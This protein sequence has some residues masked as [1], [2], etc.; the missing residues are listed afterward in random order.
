MHVARVPLALVVLGHEGEAAPLVVGDLLGPGL[1]DAVVVAGSQRVGVAER[2]LVL[3]EVALSLRRFHRHPRGLH[4]VADAPQ[5][6][7]H[8][9]GTEQRVVD[10]VE[11]RRCQT[12]VRVFP[13]GL[14][15]VAEDD[16]LELGADV[17]LQPMGGE[18]LE[19]GAQDLA[20]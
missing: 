20:G 5:Q 14:V 15:G 6:R 10:V 11:V 1:V 2:D 7:L 3:P 17:R 18:P 12:P 9:R 8:P 4:V 13:R 16:E 19:L